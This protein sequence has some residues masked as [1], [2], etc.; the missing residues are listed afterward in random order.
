M[1]RSWKLVAHRVCFAHH[2]FKHFSDGIFYY[3][4]ICNNKNKETLRNDILILN[5]H[6]LCPPSAEKCNKNMLKKN[7][8]HFH[9]SGSLGLVF[10]VCFL[11]E[12]EILQ[13]FSHIFTLKNILVAQIEK[14]VAFIYNCSLFFLQHLTSWSPI[15]LKCLHKSINVTK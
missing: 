11:F 14:L 15:S 2:K 3:L 9:C 8:H 5:F 7:K 6:Y 1:E 13:S 10:Y 4:L 12:S